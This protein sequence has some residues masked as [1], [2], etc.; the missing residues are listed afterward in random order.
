MKEILKQ[1]LSKSTLDKLKNLKDQMKTPEERRAL[2]WM[3]MDKKS[4]KSFLKDPE[5]ALKLKQLQLFGAMKKTSFL[6]ESKAFIMESVFED[7]YQL[8]KIPLPKDSKCKIID[9]GANVGA[10]AIAARGCFH[11]ATIHCYEPH[12]SLEPYLRLQAYATGA[13]YFMEAVGLQEGYFSSDEIQN[14][15]LQSE[16]VK[17]MDFTKPGKI[18]VTPLSECL[19]RIGGYV[20]ILKLDCEGS[21]W[22][23]LKDKESLKKIRFL[24]VEFHRLCPDKSFDIYDRTIDMHQKAKQFVVDA[25]FDILFE[26]YHTIDA[27]IIVAER[28]K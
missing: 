3:G 19:E 26:R 10:F 25:G 27:G 6:K 5:G 16:S 21:E 14:E 20:D 11:N 1:V 28:K 22:V 12:P 8:E 23:I 15:I 13:K 7:A 4:Y 24:T 9:I 18:K 2:R 17:V